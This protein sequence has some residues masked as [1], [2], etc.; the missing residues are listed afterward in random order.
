[1]PKYKVTTPR[2]HNGKLYGPA[3]R[4]AFITVNKPYPK[5]ETPEGLE[6]VTEVVA[7]KD[8]NQEVDRDQIKSAMLD[9]I[10]D[11]EGLSADG[12]PNMAPLQKKVKKKV[13]QALR[14]ELMTEIKND[15]Q[16]Q[17]E[18]DEMTF[19][20]SDAGDGAVKTL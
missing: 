5:G 14:D 9:M 2:F 18:K 10:K 1:M 19:I 13:G 17:I 12:I 16:T 7:K 3:T 4:R 15:E 11:K 6:L 20:D 8:A